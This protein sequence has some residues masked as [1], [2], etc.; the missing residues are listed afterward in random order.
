MKVK[1]VFLSLALSGKETG[2]KRR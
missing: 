2:A 1:G